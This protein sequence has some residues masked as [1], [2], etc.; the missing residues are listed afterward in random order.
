MDEENDDHLGQLKKSLLDNH[1]HD[2]GPSHHSSVFARTNSDYLGPSINCSPLD[3]FVEIDD[4]HSRYV[5]PDQ[6]TSS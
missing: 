6:V 2:H 5:P 1:D 4:S 3:D